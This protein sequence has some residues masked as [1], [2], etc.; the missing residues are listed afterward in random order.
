MDAKSPLLSKTLWVNLVLALSAIFVPSVGA[1]I[2]AHPDVTAVVFAGINM[3]L[4]LVTK[5]PIEIS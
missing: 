5:K 2:Q 1:F 3:V 4:R